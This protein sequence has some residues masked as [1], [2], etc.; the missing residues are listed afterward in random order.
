M[1]RDADVTGGGGEPALLAI[2]ADRCTAYGARA[3]VTAAAPI[4]AAIG[5]E[6]IRAGGN[7]FDGAVAAA[8][9]ETVL[10]PPK[11]GLAGDLVALGLE[12]GAEEPEALLA[13]GGA[14]SGL[15]D[16]TAAGR[17]E[18]TGPMS[19]G[20]PGAPVGY[21][22]LVE[23]A[24]FPIER[25]A[26]PAIDL[27]RTGIV[28]APVCET[29][30]QEARALVAEHHPGGTRYH[31]GG[32]PLPAG[33]SLQLPGLA[34]ALEE[35]ASRGSTLLDGPVGAAI[36]DAVRSRGGILRL[37]DLASAR[38]EWVA[39]AHARCGALDMYATPPPT[40]GPTL[41]D[42][43][44]SSPGDGEPAGV[45]NRVRAAIG[46]Q[47]ATLGDSVLQEGTSVVTATTVDGGA[48]VVV[49]SNSFPQFGSGIVVTDFD[50]VLA[51]RAGRGFIT[52]PGHPN[53]PLPG[54]RP[55]T[56]LHA[57]AVGD[58][59]TGLLLMG[60][61]PGGVNQVPW[62]AQLLEQ[63]LQGERHPGRLV[64][65]PRWAWVSEE[66]GIALEAGFHDRQVQDLAARVPGG[67]RRTTRW[68]VRSAQQV[69]ALGEGIAV[70]AVDPRS[71]GAAIGV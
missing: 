36:V 41:L 6:A 15:A 2:M 56:T 18:A 23:R 12:P 8:L 14:P 61:T 38:A 60:A 22:A 42:A 57:W 70:A 13:I 53:F 67:I 49:H 54:R 3:V 64:T 63:V 68:A 17:L 62:N 47:Q 37:D 26:R 31:P 19:V 59:D 33:Q 9:A 65:A 27:A 11:C 40:H 28:W 71:G 45:W 50:L 43:V 55:A 25:L 24:V 46:R 10:L 29:L 52:E 44:R 5:A 4:A 58:D 7:A 20:V 1:V 16:A 21:A 69:V 48:V 51:N 30:A 39:A 66:A 35:F 34:A 32:V